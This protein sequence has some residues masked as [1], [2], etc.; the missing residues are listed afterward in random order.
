IHLGSARRALRRFDESESAFLRAEQVLRREARPD[1]ATLANV[2]NSLGA[3]YADWGM[4][5]QA[6]LYLQQSLEAQGGACSPIV[7]MTT[8]NLAAIA[9]RSGR[10]EEAEKAYGRA[11]DCA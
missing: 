7:A 2:W 8:T 4:E 3:L 9:G 1:S 6:A 11:I 5:N 10:P